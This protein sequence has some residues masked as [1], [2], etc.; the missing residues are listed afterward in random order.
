MIKNDERIKTQKEYNHKIPQL[1]FD[2]KDELNDE[3]YHEDGVDEFIGT[4]KKDT[5]NDDDYDN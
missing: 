1:G 5:Y 3:Q 4:P 2:Y